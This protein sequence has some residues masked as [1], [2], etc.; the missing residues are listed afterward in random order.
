MT[1]DPATRND[2]RA[3]DQLRP[4][5]FELGWMDHA[6]GSCLVQ[7]GGTTILCTASVEN[8]LPRWRQGGEA[9]WVTAEYAMLPRATHTRS[10]REREGARGRTQEIQRLIGRSLRSVV[11]LEG[12]GPR[13]ITID[14]DV[15]KADGGT[16]TAAITAGWIALFLACD[17]LVQDGVIPGHP[18][19]GGVAAVSVG[20]VEGRPLLDLPYEEDVRAE[21]DL[22][23]VATHDGRLVEVQGT[24]EGAPFSRADLDSMV[25]LAL[26][27]IGQLA[28]LQRQALQE[29]NGG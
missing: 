18:L 12:L 24:A 21:V 4:I 26:L 13:T 3:P 27:G 28:R 29:Q 22:N 20:I 16:R 23:V 8:R 1:S 10:G 11:D 25:D 9:G 7:A 19:T 17:R 15:L 14:C 5:E 2:G 6:E